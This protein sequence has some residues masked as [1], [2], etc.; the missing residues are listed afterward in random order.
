MNTVVSS[1]TGQTPWL[2]KHGQGEEALLPVDIAVGNLPEERTVDVAV[3]ALRDT[4]RRIYSKVLEATGSSLRRQK[5]NYDK[6][7]AG[8]EI[9]VD[10]LVR[11]EN[12]QVGELDKSF[13]PK[14]RDVLY[15][16]TER[17]GDVNLRI[18]SMDADK[19]DTRIVH[20]NQLKLVDKPRVEGRPQRTVGRPVR[21]N[22][23]DLTDGIPKVQ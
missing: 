17:L 7:V 2:V 22:D 20:F 4:Q 13:K 14:F 11:Y 5:R 15:K 9:K 1:T 16:V 3:R 12:H 23:Y 6:L 21:L 8:P 18:E 19:P 10:D